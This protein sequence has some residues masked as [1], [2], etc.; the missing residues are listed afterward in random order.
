MDSTDS[1]IFPGNP[2]FTRKVAVYIPSQYVPGTPAP[3]IV[4]CDQYGLSTN[5]GVFQNTLDNMIA[6]KR[7]P[8]IVAVMI[9]KWRPLERSMEYDTVSGKYAEFVESEVLP[10]A[11]KKKPG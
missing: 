2:A 7:L 10:H 9:A 11:S 3:L 4:S 5:T 1:K 8:V 6:D